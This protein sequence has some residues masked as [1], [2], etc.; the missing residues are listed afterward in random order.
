MGKVLA[1]VLAGGRSEPL[2]VLTKHRAMAAVPFGGRY[3]IID[4][5]LSNC[6][7]SRVTTVQIATQYSPHSLQQHIVQGRPWDLDRR[8][9]GVWLL[10]PYM[11]RTD[12]NWYRGTADALYQN[13]DMIGTHRPDMI[14]VL[15]AD[16]VYRMDYGEMIRQHRR[17]K[18]DV[19]MAVKAMAPTDSERFGMVEVSGNRVVRFDEKPARTS[20][21]FV[22]MAIYLFEARW[23]IDRLQDC[24][25]GGKYDL[26]WDL[27]IPAVSER[28]VAPFLFEGYWEDLG[29]LDSYY[30]ANRSLLPAASTYLLDRQWPIYTP[31]EE[32]PPSKFGAGATVHNSVIANGCRVFGRVE[33]SLLF[34][35]VVVGEGSLVRDSILFSGAQVHRRCR[36]SR[37]ILDKQV[38]VG[39]G[40]VLGTDQAAPASL[41]RVVAGAPEVATEEGLL[42][43]G[44]ATRVPPGFECRRAAM[45]D[46][47]LDEDAV[48]AAATAQVSGA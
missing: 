33:N 17:N 32:R 31:S 19:T 48:R 12:S 22:N 43:V 18:A 35:G 15:S 26:V 16:Q 46:S 38:V 34:P 14:L 30:L 13:L 47:H 29:T 40:A 44:K 5:T 3:R 36:V 25:P 27:L 23:L 11:G 24:V 42:V 6:V 10:Q 21:S 4:F 1:F 2:G 39:D 28:R 7:H 9:G 37:C 45:I 8:D 41:G 20:L